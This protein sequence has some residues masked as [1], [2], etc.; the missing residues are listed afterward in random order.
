MVF[1]KTGQIF[2]HARGAGAVIFFLKK[3]FA[4]KSDSPPLAV[5]LR[6]FL[7][8]KSVVFPSLVF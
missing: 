6:D 2:F 7:R 4:Q 3:T 8:P 1:L 5:F